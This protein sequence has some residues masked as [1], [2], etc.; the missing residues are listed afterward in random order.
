MMCRHRYHRHLY[1]PPTGAGGNFIRTGGGAKQQATHG[2]KKRKRPTATAASQH[3]ARQSAAAT[4]NRSIFCCLSLSTSI[5][6]SFHFHFHLHHDDDS[7]DDDEGCGGE[8]REENRFVVDDDDGAAAA[9]AA[10]AAAAGCEVV[11]FDRNCPGRRDGATPAAVRPKSPQ[12]RAGKF[13]PRDRGIDMYRLEA[14]EPRRQGP[15]NS[16]TNKATSRLGSF[17]PSRRGCAAR[18]RCTPHYRKFK[19]VR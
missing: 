18:A 13:V 15:G 4:A 9:S 19:F 10:P 14:K 6:F 12:G 7:Q 17:G 8:D 11:R 16:Q 1:H 2:R 3:E 5:S